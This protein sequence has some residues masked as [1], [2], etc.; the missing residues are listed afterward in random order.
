MSGNELFD[1]RILILEDHDGTQDVLVWQV[2]LIG[3]VALSTKTGKD[4][5]EKSIIENPELIL[6]NIELPEM[7]ESEQR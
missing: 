4:G 1:D 2:E 3:F 6:L 7:A 5:L